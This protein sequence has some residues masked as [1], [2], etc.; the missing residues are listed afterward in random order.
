MYAAPFDV[1][2]NADEADDTVVQPDL[3]VVCDQSKL[4]DKGC[5][6][7]PDLIIEILSPSTARF[8]RMLKFQQYL[9]AGVREY[10]MV[11]PLE[12]IVQVCIWKDG[13]YFIMAYADTDTVPVSVLPGLEI[14]LPEVFTQAEP[15]EA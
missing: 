6:G 2:L 11:D 14:R 1:R 10:W 8:D 4:D 12:Q 5:K 15:R 13:K 3:L 7:A 9:K